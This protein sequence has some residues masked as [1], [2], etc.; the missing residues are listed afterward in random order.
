[1]PTGVLALPFWLPVYMFTLPLSSPKCKVGDQ[2]GF[3]VSKIAA[4]DPDRKCVAQILYLFA[5]SRSR[6]ALPSLAIHPERLFSDTMRVLSHSFLRILGILQKK[7]KV[8]FIVQQLF[9]LHAHVPYLPMNASERT[10]VTP[11]HH[12]LDE[13]RATQTTTVWSPLP[14]CIALAIACDA[15]KIEVVQN[16]A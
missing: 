13:P 16:P 7:T 2:S 4:G 9:H 15:S 1:M 12:P 10:A 3:K 14:Q 11:W 6:S 8:V 5:F